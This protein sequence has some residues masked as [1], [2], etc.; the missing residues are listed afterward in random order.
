M[1]NTR[2][3][4]P[5]SA[6]DDLSPFL[7]SGEAGAVI[8]KPGDASR[9][10]FFVQRGRVEL[11]TEAGG[12]VRTETLGLGDFF[13]EAALL[14]EQPR[15]A[16]AKALTAFT[17]VKLDRATFDQLAAAHA[18]IP[19]RMLTALIARD[20]ERPLAVAPLPEPAP[21]PPPP[22]AKAHE[23][24]PPA[25]V[26]VEKAVLNHKASKKVFQLAAPA[27]AIIGRQDRGTGFVP[28]VDLT[29][30]DTDRTL[31]R[32][33]AVIVWRDGAFR[34]HEEKATRNGTF[35]NG[36]RLG[37]GAD[38]ELKDGDRLRCGLVELVF[39]AK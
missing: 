16:T 9:E 2:P 31:S 21:P 37:A 38:A 39:H 12:A 4:N 13:G 7:V 27:T 22:E 19:G 36:Q 10:V 34:V 15:T 6:P 30:L 5:A 18:E 1:A 33:H 26:S 28:E 17:L 3:D 11:V 32:R 24:A 35:V 20:R 14:D 29:D 8:F 25:R 23:P